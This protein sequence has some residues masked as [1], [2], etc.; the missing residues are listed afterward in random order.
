MKTLAMA[1][2]LALAAGAASAGVIYA[3]DFNSNTLGA[4]TYQDYRTNGVSSYKWDTNQDE[5]LGNFTGGLGAAAMSNSGDVAGPYDHAIISP[6]INLPEGMITLSFL[7][8]YQNFA[9]IDFADV[10]ISN[11]NGASWDNVL[12]FNEDH[13]AFYATPGET[14]LIDLT[15][16]AGQAVKIRFHHYDNEEDANDWYWQI[17]DI[18]VDATAIP[19]PGAVGLLGAAG[20]AAARRRR[21]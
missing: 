21:R 7:T 8:N 2:T 4:F 18:A 17:D 19:A 15:D 5:L 6:S 11:N 9:N 3:E 1:L 20:L 10:D 13:G 14:A 12:R 16:Y